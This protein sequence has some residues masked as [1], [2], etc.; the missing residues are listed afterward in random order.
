[1]T[2]LT[3]FGAGKIGEAIIHL[4]GH[5]GDYQLRVVDSDPAR[6]APMREAAE[7][8]EADISRPGELERLVKGQDVVVSACPFY[9][10]P[11]IATA[12]R[13]AGAQYLDL[14]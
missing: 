8:L 14:T 10:T 3:L 1:M 9:L 13:H 5:T 12:A 11:A 2:R 4:L 7:C 6:L